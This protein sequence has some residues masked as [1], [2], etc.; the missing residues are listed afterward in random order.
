MLL[1]LGVGAWSVAS[2]WLEDAR[3][4]AGRHHARRVALEEFYRDVNPDKIDSVDKTLIEAK[5]H[6][7]ELWAKLEKKYGKR[8]RKPDYLKSRKGEL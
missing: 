2:E 1:L 4:E 7:K 5:G 6:E 8:P 3:I